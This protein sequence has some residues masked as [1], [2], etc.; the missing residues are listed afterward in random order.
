MF[1]LE[2]SI[3]VNCMLY[4]AEDA[5]A[6]TMFLVP[7]SSFFNITCKDDAKVVWLLFDHWDFHCMT[8]PL[9]SLKQYSRMA[10]PGMALVPINRQLKMFLE[11]LSGYLRNGMNCKELHN[12]KLNEFFLLMRGFYTKEDIVKLMHPLLANTMDFRMFC[13]NSVNNVKNVREMIDGSGMSRSMFYEKFK[14]EF[15]D[16]SPKK[17]LDTYINQRILNTAALPSITVKE[18]MY[19]TGFSDESA[20]TQYC[21]RH[22]GQVPSQIISERAK[23][24]SAI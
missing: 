10:Q 24:K 15:G 8:T 2:G 21:K 16:V 14:A 1:V 17:W 23:A 13:F 19:K 3:N 18:L 4:P 9:K 5:V 7:A 11:L 12:L 22:F 6:G 20:F